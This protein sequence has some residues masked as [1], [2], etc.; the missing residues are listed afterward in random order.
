MAGGVAMT[1]AAR[2]RRRGSWYGVFMNAL[3]AKSPSQIDGPARERRLEMQHLQAIEGNP[4][5][6]EE[7][8]MF[9]MFEREGWSEEREHAYILDLIQLRAGTKK[10][11]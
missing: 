9:E 8:A 11:G 6:L 1:Q 7:I 2:A 10:T 5:T 4:L 3:P